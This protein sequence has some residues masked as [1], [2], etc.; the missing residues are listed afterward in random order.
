MTLVGR[1]ILIPP[2]SANNLYRF[3]RGTSMRSSEYR[4]WLSYAA[5]IVRDAVLPVDGIV[6][7][8]I[9]LHGGKGMTLKSDMDNLM[10]A[11]MDVLQPTKLDRHG[12]VV[13]HGAGV[14]SNDNLTVV[15]QIAL[16]FIPEPH[17]A[18]GAER[19]SVEMEIGLWSLNDA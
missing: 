16:K 17:R 8:Q 19:R 5:P 7:V 12:N 4:A 1:V 15:H 11:T 9:T 13:C 3:Y 10:K 6:G 14:I 18:R 2:P